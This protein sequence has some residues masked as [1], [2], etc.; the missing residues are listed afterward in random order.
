MNLYEKLPQ[1]D[2]EHIIDYIEAY[3]GIDGDGVSMKASLD[4]V[5]R[6]WN[7][8]KEDLFKVFGGQLILTKS[9]NYAKPI[10]LIEDEMSKIISYGG[11]GGDFHRAVNKL[12]Q[13]FGGDLQWDMHQLFYTEYLAKN[14]YI[15]TP[16]S[17]PTQD[18]SHK[19]VVSSGCK[20]SKVL[21]KIA[22]SYNLEGYEQFRIAHSM[23]LNQKSLKG[24]LC[25]SIHPLDYMTMSDNNCCWSSCMSWRETG[26]YRQGTVEMMNSPCVVVAYLKSADDM[27]S[28]GEHRW[29]SKKWRQLFIV[30]PELI[31][32]I[33]QYPYPSDELN[34]ITLQW[35]RELAEKNGVWGPYEDTAVEVR[36]NAT[37]PI[38]S[39]NKS[40]YFDIHTN[41]M[42]NDFYASHLSYVSESI[43]EHYDLCFSG[44]AECMKCGDD[45]SGYGGGDMETCALCCPDC[46]DIFYCSE[47]GERV[48]GD[49]LISIDGNRV[50]H[51]CYE[52]YYQ[53]CVLCDETHHENY[54]QQVY[55]R[56][57]PHHD[58]NNVCYS[59]RI[60]EDC[61]NSDKFIAL[62]GK[63][64]T[65]PYGRWNHKY[66]VDLKNLTLEG[67]EYFDVWSDTDYEDFKNAIIQR[68]SE[69][70]AVHSIDE[71]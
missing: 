59:M 41:F 22:A 20:L 71:N 60:C 46:E 63:A 55:L 31:T 36:N 54:S 5:L 52:N 9:I 48:S 24:E 30:T 27:Y 38:A 13:S 69:R 17:I 8:N 66:V 58:S 33:R 62:F 1:N 51:Y 49:D 18:G 68:A 11:E 44:E 50:C 26:D 47:C 7:R 4:H 15:G 40:V 35:L 6:F 28:V 12:A 43:P 37:V 42:Y 16:F 10:A 56:E 32:G 65:I 34:G 25:V 21:G 2:I 19:I 61:L 64:E 23:A 70:S 29:N 53:T 39:L 57:E 14:T 67:L 45:C 3:A